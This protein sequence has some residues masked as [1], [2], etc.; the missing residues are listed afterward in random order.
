MRALK[1]KGI[2]NIEKA[3]HP[4]SHW[5]PR[6]I[7]AK[8][9]NNPSNLYT[10]LIR[11]KQGNRRKNKARVFDS[12]SLESLSHLIKVAVNWDRPPTNETWASDP[13][14]PATKIGHW[15]CGKTKR[16]ASGKRVKGKA[17][18]SEREQKLWRPPKNQ[19]SSQPSAI[20][21]TW[22][23]PWIRSG[24]L[25]FQVPSS[26]FHRTNIRHS[27][28]CSAHVSYESLSKASSL[29]SMNS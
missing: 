5:W 7:L 9:H 16:K 1:S 26:C 10:L 29:F 3:S 21:K 6:N 14:A 11:L 18:I 4:F 22:S 8:F 24:R 20:Q 15:I 12:L 2:W 25:Y 17:L 28:F 13:R 23:L 19:T 27:P